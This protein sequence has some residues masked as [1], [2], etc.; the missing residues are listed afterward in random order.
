MKKI[1]LGFVLLVATQTVAFAQV[2]VISEKMLPWTERAELFHPVFAPNGDYLLLTGIDFKGLVKYDLKTNEMTKLTD[3]VNAGYQPQVS[4]G[5][6]VVV[7]RSVEYKD[8]RRF[9]SI[10]SLNL[11]NRKVTVIDEPSREMHA[12]AFVGGNV[13][14]ASP[15]WVISKRL[16]T[17][18][19]T[20]NTSYI[21]TIEDQSLVLYKDNVRKVLNPNGN[22]SYIWPSVSPDQKHIVY[23][24]LDNG[25]ATCVCDMDGKNVIKLGYIGAPVWMGN[26]WIVGMEDIDDGHQT[27]SSKLKA[28]KIDGSYTQYIPTKNKIAMYPAANEKSIVYVADGAVYLMDITVR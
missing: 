4:D 7:Y 2:N 22:G 18:I 8:N 26:S 24:S 19:R 10:Q 12:F 13:K 16:A 9:T 3:A 20:V 17:D 21:V 14:V 28:A 5:G 1:M 27:T 25:C 11:E 6:K 23:M 15:K